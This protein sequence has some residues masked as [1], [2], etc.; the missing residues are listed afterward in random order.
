MGAPVRIVLTLATCATLFASCSDCRPAR[1]GIVFHASF[2]IVPSSRGQVRQ[3][4]PPAR[5][6]PVRALSGADAG[7]RVGWGGGGAGAFLRAGRKR[8]QGQC[9]EPVARFLGRGEGDRGAGRPVADP[10]ARHLAAR[11]RRLCPQR[12]RACAPPA[13]ADARHCHRRRR[14]AAVHRRRGGGG[15][16]AAGLVAG[17]PAPVR[18]P[19]RAWWRSS[20]R[21]PS[22]A[23]PSLATVDGPVHAPDPRQRRQPGRRDRGGHPAGILP[24]FLRQYRSRAGCRRQ[25]DAAGCDR[26]RAQFAR[27][28]QPPHGRD[29]SRRTAL[30]R[31]ERQRRLPQGEPPGR[32]RTLLCLAQARRIRAGGHGRPGGARYPG[33]FR[34]AARSDAQR[35]PGRVARAGGAGLGRDRRG[36]PPPATGCGTATCAAAW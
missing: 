25:P 8:R 4:F 29:D 14:P 1:A 34:P 28:R 9:A 7:C 32:H 12:D 20:L 15:H 27:G 5:V 36:R 22:G 31:R 16:G 6:A 21:Q 23:Q 30:G 35:G 11:P 24:A 10:A 3:L 33:A 19:S 2:H 17:R 26:D 13:G 18:H